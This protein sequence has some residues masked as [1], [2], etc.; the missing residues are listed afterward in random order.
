MKRIEKIL[1]LLL[2]LYSLGPTYGQEPKI[3]F[4]SDS[5]LKLTIKL[6]LNEVIH[7]LKIRD[8]HEA[9]LSYTDNN[10]LESTHNIKLKVRGKSRSK[11]N[12]CKFPP[13]EIN[14]K[15]NKTKNSLFEGQNKIKLVTHC[16]YGSE[17]RRYVAEEYFIYKMYQT[18]SPYS[19]N[20]RLCEITYIDLDKS[21]NQFT[22]IGF[23]IEPIKDVAERN[24]MVVYKDTIAHQDLCNR[25]EL[26]K[27]IFFQYMIGNMD[28]EIALRHNIKLIEYREGG[29]PIAIPYDFDFS[30]MINTSYAAPPEGFGYQK[31]VRNRSFRGFCRFN[32]GY[33]TTLDFYQKI[34]PDIFTLVR[35]S[36]YLTERN[37]NSVEKYLESFYKVMDDPKKF[38]QKINRACWIDHEH[39]YQ[40]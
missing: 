25:K 33:S 27:L 12:I 36:N 5:I 2:I 39:L 19:H 14:F 18:V 9:I 7:D 16:N 11:V 1:F 31:S 3:L 40:K 22:K 17:F 6:H 29:F 10:N 30:G 26:D 24:D 38:N 34:K 28:W 13:L 8:D 21:K 23:L 15:K 37:K 32:N 35:T 20:V 4:Q